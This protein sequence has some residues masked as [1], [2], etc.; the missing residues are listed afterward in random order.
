[1]QFSDVNYPTTPYNKM[2]LAEL[3][4]EVIAHFR[5]QL[6]DSSHEFRVNPDP[7]DDWGAFVDAAVAIQNL[8]EAVH[9]MRYGDT[10]FNASGAPE[11]EGG[12]A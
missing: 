4:E 11:E 10:S 7:T 6:F 3:K 5:T 8:E 9:Q 12:A 2:T 1:M